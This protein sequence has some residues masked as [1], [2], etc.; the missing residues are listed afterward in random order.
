MRHGRSLSLISYVDWPL[1]VAVISLVA[2]GLAAIYSVALGQGQGQFFNFEKQL[3]W[4]AIGLFI[5]L[6]VANIHYRTWQLGSWWLFGLGLILLI[7]VLTPLG[8]TIRGTRG[9]F[10]LGPV[11]FQPVELVK[12]FLIFALADIASRYGRAVHRLWHLA[13]IG[14]VAFIP[15]V[16][17]MLQPD[18]GSGMV[19]F[20]TWLALFILLAKRKWHVAL[21]LIGMVAIFAVAWVGV[22]QDYQKE[23][24][25]TFLDPGRDPLGRGY[26]V[27]QSLIAVGAG[28]VFGRGLGFGSQS[29]LKFIP[30][31]QTDFI[32]AV[33][34]EE[35][36]FIGVAL[37]I[38]L[39]ALVF[40]R[41][42][43]IARRAPDDFSMFVVVLAAV[44][45]FV[46]IFINIGMC[47]GLLPVTGISLPLVSYGGS[48]LLTVLVLLGVIFNINKM[49]TLSQ[50]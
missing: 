35:L 2:I 49:S 17:V 50:N 44:L 47:I 24:V 1:L 6:V 48:F 39:F 27:R 42:Y 43:R 16:L 7:L 25:L 30:E 15:F 20:F 36:G 41:L 26:N 9:W 45:L 40:Y 10:S 29:Q 14:V 11:S 28:G 38:S 18:F 12:V 34:A 37:V 46:Q 33:I 3:I 13:A 22:F 19:L 4:L 23:R 32:F 31:S 8:A 21:V 5:M